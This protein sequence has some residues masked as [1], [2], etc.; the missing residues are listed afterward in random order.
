[1]F[2]EMILTLKNRRSS[3]AHSSHSYTVVRVTV[4]H[5]LVFKLEDFVV[6]FFIHLKF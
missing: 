3:G 2:G 4:L 5:L 1:M 6:V